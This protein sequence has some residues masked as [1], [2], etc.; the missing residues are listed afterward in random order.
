MAA[1]LFGITDKGNRRERNEDTFVVKELFNKEYVL[2]CVIDGVGGYSGGEVAAEIAREAIV[3]YFQKKPT[4]IIAVLKDAI[5]AA[6]FKINTERNSNEGNKQMAC[7]ITCAI[8][9]LPSNK[10]YYAH[11]GDTRLYLFRDNS[12]VKI[13][14][15]HSVVGYLEESGRLSEEDAMNHPR[16]NEINKALG[17]EEHIPVDDYIETGESPFLPADMILICSDGL[18]DMVPSQMISGILGSKKFIEEKCRDLVSAANAAGGNDNITAVLVANHKQPKKQIPVSPVERDKK[19]EL[20]NP[21]TGSKSIVTKDKKSKL[22]LVLFLVIGASVLL[23]ML[24]PLFK[25]MLAKGTD[26]DGFHRMKVL[27]KNNPAAALMTAAGDTSKTFVLSSTALPIDQP[28]VVTKDS[29]YM[30][31][32]GAIIFPDSSYTGPALKIGN[33]SKAVILDSIVFKNFDVAIIVSNNNVVFK[34]VR[35]INC[36]VPIQYNLSP[37]DSLVS[38]RLKDSV[39]TSR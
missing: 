29:F 15:D 27:K 5:A 16:R 7:V 2:A 34:N 23:G 39:F 14:K 33:Q 32:N 4:D 36:R 6:N 9:H 12:L 30:T 10:F 8:V 19:N 11:V 17:F 1:H 20:I 13:T 35:F 37:G 31:G 28:V 21:G 25:N 26:K 3:G 22:P 38:G 18:T 24:T